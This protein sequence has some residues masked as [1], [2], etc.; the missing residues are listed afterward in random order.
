MYGLSRIFNLPMVYQA[1][2]CAFTKKPTKICTEIK[3]KTGV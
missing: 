1:I 2:L 3:I